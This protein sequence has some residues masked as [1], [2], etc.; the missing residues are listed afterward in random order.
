MTED[1]LETENPT[2]CPVCAKKF[3]KFNGMTQHLQSKADSSHEAYRTIKSLVKK[4][5]APHASR[6]D[7]RFKSASIFDAGGGAAAAGAEGGKGKEEEEEEEEEAQAQDTGDFS[8]KDEALTCRGCSGSF[9][10]TVKDQAF[11]TARGFIHKPARCRQCRC[12]RP[13]SP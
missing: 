4:L 12:P 8:G 5:R 11:Y 9:V 1:E 13:K 3:G 7:L 2:T 6:Y 10:F